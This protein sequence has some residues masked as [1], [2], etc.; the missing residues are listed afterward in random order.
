MKQGLGMKLSWGVQ[1]VCEGGWDQ[2]CV[3]SWGCEKVGWAYG[4]VTQDRGWISQAVA[5]HRAAWVACVL[6]PRN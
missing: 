2:L 4:V 6:H 1:R 5:D 3:C